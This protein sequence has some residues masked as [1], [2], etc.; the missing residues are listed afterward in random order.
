MFISN[1]PVRDE[2]LEQISG[3]SSG[4]LGTVDMMGK[5]VRRVTGSAHLI[6]P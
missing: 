2:I 3:E 5:K 1:D 6:R 4:A